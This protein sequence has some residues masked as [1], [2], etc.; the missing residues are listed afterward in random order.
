MSH[1]T[2]L[3]TAPLPPETTTVQQESYVTYTCH[4]FDS[5]EES[6]RTITILEKRNLISGSGTTGFRT[7]EA[8]LH[9]STYLLTPV[10]KQL[11]AGKSVFE[12]GAGTGLLSILCAR[13][14]SA[15]HVTITDGDEGV[16]ETLKSNLF[17]NELQDDDSVVT[18]VLRW[19]RGLK[20]TWVEEDCE[21]HPYDVVLGAD[22]VGVH[23]C[24][25]SFPYH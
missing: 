9:L 17:L 14:L 24:A 19:G 8:A 10:G 25:V 11:I 5:R 22:I 18:G 20:D 16:I 15:K 13:H 23:H 21:E 2:S 4:H 7:W 12:L 1:L 3:I 6:E